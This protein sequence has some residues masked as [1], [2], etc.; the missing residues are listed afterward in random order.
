MEIVRR[1][2]SSKKSKY[3]KYLAEGRREKNK[4]RKLAK[5][6]LNYDEEVK[7][8]REANQKFQEFLA[9]HPEERIRRSAKKND[10]DKG[11][12]TITYLV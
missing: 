11:N 5:L 6:G 1:V 9:K 7:K 4:R 8:S 10:K 2:A 12:R 3:G